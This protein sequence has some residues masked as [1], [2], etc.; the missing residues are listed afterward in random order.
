MGGKTFTPRQQNWKWFADDAAEPTSQLAN[1]NVAPTLASSN[2]IRL[3]VTIAEVGGATGSGAV[4]VEYSTDDTNF[5]AFGAGNHWNYANGQATAGNTTTTFKTSDATTNG[6]YHESGTLSETWAASAIRELDFAVQ[7]TAGASPGTLYY[8]RL[9]IAGLLFWIGGKHRLRQGSLLFGYLTGYGIHLLMAGL[10]LL[11][12]FVI[13]AAAQHPQVV[14]LF[15]FAAVFALWLLSAYDLVRRVAEAEA[16]AAAITTR[17]T[18]GEEV[19]FTIRAQAILSSVYVRDAAL[20]AA[21]G[22]ARVSRARRPAVGGSAAR[23]W[24]EDVPAPVARG[25]RPRGARAPQPSGDGLPHAGVRPRGR[26][27]AGPRAAARLERRRGARA[28]GG[29]AR[30]RC[31]KIEVRAGQ[32]VA[33]AKAVEESPDSTG[34]GRG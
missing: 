23:L 25:Q 18:K 28:R 7:Q 11:Y 30:A 5:T 29:S 12:P 27:G 31:D 4:S 26:P 2:I 32:T 1:E 17:F 3:R 13:Q 14:G 8:F 20:D 6:L 22:R 10:A 19:L 16:Q 33:A 24:R 34:Q 9:L 15:G 21:P